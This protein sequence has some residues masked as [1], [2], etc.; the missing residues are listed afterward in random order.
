MRVT[1]KNCLI[2][3][4]TPTAKKSGAAGHH[5]KRL[6]QVNRYLYVSKSKMVV[7]YNN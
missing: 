6:A 2:I 7:I 3:I 5:I 4:N 1:S